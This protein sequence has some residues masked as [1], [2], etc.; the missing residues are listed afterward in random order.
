MNTLL[1]PENC[2]CCAPLGA[3]ISHAAC[4]PP[5]PTNYTLVA[6]LLPDEQ[7]CPACGEKLRNQ[8]VQR[9]RCWDCLSFLLLPGETTDDII[10]MRSNKPDM[11]VYN[12]RR[13]KA[14]LPIYLWDGVMTTVI[15][16]PYKPIK[17][18]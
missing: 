9:R 10:A 2:V 8:A 6:R 16:E 4:P 18:I 11:P 1:H 15:F 5:D 12:L 14:M 7:L 17:P 3:I 13:D